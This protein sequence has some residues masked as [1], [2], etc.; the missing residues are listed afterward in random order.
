MYEAWR[1]SLLVCMLLA[2]ADVPISSAFNIDTANA[3]VYRGKQKDFFGYKVLQYMSARSKGIIVT[4][5]LQLNGS[6]GI[7]KHDQ[8]HT[9]KWF[10]PND[11]SE[12]HPYSAKHLGLSIAPDSTGSHFIAC[13][14]SL[15]HP[16]DENV[17]LNSLCYNITDDFQLLSS[18]KPLF[19]KCIKKTVNLVF[20][21][22]GS[23]SM[24]GTE[25]NENKLFITNIMDSLKN[26]SFKFAAVQFS[27]N[28]STV[29]NF[30]D[31]TDGTALEKLEKEGHMKSLTNTH[32]ALNFTLS[33]L[34]ENKTAGA[35]KDAIKAV[36]II[37]DGN[38]SDL[39]R[40]YKSIETYK[41]KEIIR[42]VIG[43]KNVRLDK[44]KEIASEP[45]DKNVFKIENYGGLKG[46]LE[47]FQ[48]QI[49][50]IEGSSVVR[51]EE[52]TNQMSQS[53]FS[54][55]SYK[56]TLILGSVGTNTWRGALNNY[57]N[58]DKM[59]VVPDMEQ[60]SYM[61]YSLSAGERNGNPLCFTGA[62]RFNHMGQVVV[63]QRDEDKWKT[64][65]RITEN[66][67]GSYFGAELCSV[68]IDSDGNTDFLLVGAPLFYLPEERKE[69]S[70]YIYSLSD[71]MELERKHQV[72]APS[73]GR[74]GTTI[75]SLS[76]LNG[77]GL[78]DVAVGAPLEE[79]NAGAIYIYLGQGG[80]G[81]RN[82]FS[83]RITGAEF[84]P[85][86]R[87][88]GQAISGD[89]DLGDDRLPDIVVGS[90]GAAV[91]LRS[92]PVLDVKAKMSFYP[93][94]ISIQEINCLQKENIL[95]M[96]TIT[97]C[98]E[99]VEATNSIA[100]P[101]INISCMLN[102]DP[103]RQTYR[104][105]FDKTE[106][107]SRNI[108]RTYELSDKETCFNY[109]I[110][111]TTCIKDTL[112]PVNIKLNFSQTDSENST[113]ILNVDS[114]R[115]AVVEVPF[116]KHCEK[117]ICIADLKVEFNFTSKEVLVTENGGISV[118]ITLDNKADDS[119]N[120]SLTMHY[121][122]G[123]SFSKMD[124]TGTKT[125]T[126][127]CTGRED[128]LD[129][130]VCGISLPVY[131]SKSS[132]KFNATFRVAKMF[133]W[134]DTMSMTISAK[135]ENSNSSKRSSVTRSIP[136]KYSVRMA[137]AVNDK[138]VSYLNFT[139]ES[140]TPKPMT[141]VYDIENTGFKDF[142]INVSL[143]FPS[144]LKH[145][146][147]MKDYA[148][149]VEPNTT[150]CSVIS[151]EKS[152]DCPQKENCV[153]VKCDTFMLKNYLSGYSS[154]RIS[155]VGKVHFQNLENHV[156]NMPFLKQ[157]T[158]DGGEVNFTSIIKVHHDGSKY[159]LA[160]H[161]DEKKN[162]TDKGEVRKSTAARVEFIVPQNRK[163]ITMT[164][165]ILGF[166]LLIILTI[167]MWKCGCFKR[168]TIEDYEQQMAATPTQ[169]RNS[170]VSSHNKPE[171]VEEEKKPLNENVGKNSP[172][173]NSEGDHEKID[174][175]A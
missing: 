57:Q 163:L 128:V 129:E 44:L 23:E 108:T 109:S 127:I 119:Y 21:F 116:E 14:P 157:Y 159:V 118:L 151:T 124:Q 32:K 141:I 112:S 69:G 123:L 167:I 48:K 74:F 165:V 25:F 31:Y 142:P 145:N 66:Q 131:R 164:G 113:A 34:L 97:A 136:V 173:A 22:D 70:I 150:Q 153:A 125:L 80:I 100:G 59:I 39:D 94:V 91:V 17:F 92:K 18:F 149:T 60:D 61:G 50:S 132:A 33:E 120:T 104:G 87:F 130:T 29:F 49:F 82:I 6:G 148:V 54:A 19:Q 76:D 155:L 84:H 117:E 11:F 174:H 72:K 1:F 143:F 139:P 2:A 162:P 152:E 37:T 154:V 137:V 55:V 166:I 172:L 13:S 43:V 40:N 161:K 85:G 15:A 4:A 135:S 46:I 52:L 77:D 96:I 175:L 146:F 71:K 121:P 67:I 27:T 81:M 160:S 12:T 24:T 95:P 5:P 99:M 93:N 171:Q 140:H 90:Q 102:V 7:F 98:F 3:T 8:D 62:P 38:P 89:I 64:V 158:G 79:N 68:D 47:N 63:F 168:K 78:R 115:Q 9:E 36:V 30:N 107:N 133:E 45:K 58:Q 73:M 138:T 65:Q 28:C 106:T 53:G 170:S 75:S 122:P 10:S 26:T 144:K 105:F 110:Y 111:M 16:C 20:L 51:S 156:S 56:D 42:V 126:H 83:Q 147:E 88:F 35:S 101:G 103:M 169:R 114:K 134:N 41:R 86:L